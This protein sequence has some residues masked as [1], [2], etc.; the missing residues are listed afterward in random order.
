MRPSY[1]NKRIRR[2]TITASS[3]STLDD[4]VNN[5][6]KTH[7]VIAETTSATLINQ[8]ILLWIA[9]VYYEE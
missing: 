4:D 9:T 5:F 7:N 3:P 2:K 8:S 1:E 6:R